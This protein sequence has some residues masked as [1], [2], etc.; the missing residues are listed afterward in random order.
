LGEREIPGLLRCWVA[1][2]ACVFLW[3]RLYL[4]KT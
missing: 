3:L 2:R 4:L 1:R